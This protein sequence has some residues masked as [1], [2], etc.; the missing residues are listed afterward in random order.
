MLANKEDNQLNSQLKTTSFFH[1]KLT[2]AEKRYCKTDKELLA[3]VL[4]IRKI[5]VYL[6]KLFDLI[7]DHNALS[8]LQTLHM[9]DERGRHERWLELFYNNMIS[10]SQKANRSQREKTTADNLF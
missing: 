8:W 3:S 5:T 2:S 7:T 9:T 1:H 6:A 4:A 10:M